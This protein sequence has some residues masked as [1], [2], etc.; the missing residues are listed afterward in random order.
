MNDAHDDPA[1][2][3]AFLDGYLADLEAGRELELAEYLARF[4]GH[5]D[6]VEREWRGLREGSADEP[7]AFGSYRIQRELGRGGQG[8]VHLAL[9]ARLRRPVALKLLGG[10][11]PGQ[12]LVL[13][14]FRRE[15]EVAS[16]LEHPGICSVFD[17]GVVGNTAY[18][19]MQYVEG[20][21]LAARIAAAR[22]GGA[23]RIELPGGADAIVLLFEKAA[24]A[25]H[26]AHE[27]GVV[28]RDVKPGNVMVT[29]AGEPVLLDFG[30]ARDESAEASGLTLTGDVFGT[31]AYMSPEQVAGLRTDNRTDVYSLAATLYECLTLERPFR[32]PTREALYQEILEL[33]PDDVRE[34]DTSLPS[35]L[36]VVLATALEKDLDRRYRTAEELKLELRRV[37]EHEPI[38]A[39]PISRLGRMWRF[40]R[41]NPALAATTAIA[42]GLLVVAFVVTALWLRTSEESRGILMG[43]NRDLERSLEDAR[44]GRL[45][46]KEERVAALVEQGFQTF[47]AG[48]W[49]GADELFEA[50]LAEDPANLTALAGLFW[51]RTYSGGDALAL[52]DGYA[53][54]HGELPLLHWMRGRALEQCGEHE[55]ARRELALAGDEEDD[56]RLYLE[57]LRAID[58]FGYTAGPDEARASLPFFERAIAHARRPQFHYW[59]GLMMAADRAGDRARVDAAA[60]V[61]EYH[62]PDST[63]TW[64]AVAQFYFE[65]D[66]ERSLAAMHRILELEDSAMAHIGIAQH[67]LARGD[68]EEA[69]ERFDR[70]IA[71]DPELPAAYF[72]KASWLRAQGELDEPR[73]LLLRAIAI[74]IEGDPFRGVL[75]GELRAVLEAA[76]DGRATLSD[77]ELFALAAAE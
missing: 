37:R 22:A 3:A 34:H 20:E 7:G 35:D 38:Q 14:R 61:L 77:D 52:L 58:N 73:E 66:P 71:S 65:A 70:A 17:A 2:A 29:P 51:Y 10:L 75:L 21:T 67:A 27:A 15:A 53:A 60:E 6:L 16:R 19:A 50:A 54:R 25:L 68:E 12:E 36:A 41:R 11:G 24:A 40:S 47:F 28:H 1:V 5:E 30:L 33:E 45:S 31:P 49:E 26:A 69:E 44:A 62:W 23:P 43:L 63:S 72:M 8:V 74:A 55:A 42:L 9:D 32:A 13:A 64:D 39:R 76:G 48:R 56:V 18:I 59:H 46:K 4:P 57:G